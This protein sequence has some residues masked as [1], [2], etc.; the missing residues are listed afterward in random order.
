MKD[1]SNGVVI[2]DTASERYYC[3]WGWSKNLSDADIIINNRVLENKIKYLKTHHDYC[4]NHKVSVQ[5]LVLRSVHIEVTNEYCIG[6][7]VSLC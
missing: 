7:E 2:Y 1:K 3:G 5:N 4:K 6:E